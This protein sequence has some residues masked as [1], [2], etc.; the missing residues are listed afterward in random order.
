MDTSQN[1]LNLMIDVLDKLSRKNEKK[2]SGTRSNL[3]TDRGIEGVSAFGAVRG[4]RL[5]V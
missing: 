1:D 5:E 4:L 2:G 3:L